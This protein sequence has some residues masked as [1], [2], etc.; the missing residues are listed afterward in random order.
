MRRSIDLY[1]V[2]CPRC[3]PSV[4]RTGWIDP[5]VHARTLASEV[6]DQVCPA[7]FA[8]VTVCLG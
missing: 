1:Q 5:A 3:I 7:R 2:S 6:V 4:P 8:L